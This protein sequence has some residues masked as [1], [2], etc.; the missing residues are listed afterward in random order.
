MFGIGFCMNG[1]G[2]VPPLCKEG[3]RI[4]QFTINPNGSSCELKCECNNQ[5]YTGF[6]DKN[7]RCDSIPRGNCDKKG[8]LGGCIM[9]PKPKEYTCATGI[10]TCQPSYLNSRK[11]GDC[12]RL[13]K[14]E[15]E[16]DR[17]RCGDGIDNDCD[18]TVDK[19]DNDCEQY[20]NL[21]QTKSC[22][23]PENKDTINKGSCSAGLV[24]CDSSTGMWP[25]GETRHC[26]YE[27]M[28]KDEVCNGKD[29]DCDG[30][31]DEGLKDCV[32]LK[33]G[34]KE[35]CY[36]GSGGTENRGICRPGTRICEIKGD[37]TKK[38][39]KCTKEVLPND[40]DVC[41]N[42]LDDNCNGVIDEG[43]VCTS[44]ST[45]P[46]GDDLGQCR[47]GIQRCEGGRWSYTCY[48]AIGPR[49]E[50]CDGLDNNCNGRVDE[51]LVQK[52]KTA[53]GQGLATCLKGAWVCDGPSPSLETCN[54]KDDDCDGKIDN[55]LTERCETNCGGGLRVCFLGKWG[56][57]EPNE[58]HAETCNDKDDNCNGKTDE[59]LVKTCSSTC[60]KGVSICSKGTWAQC[61]A[62]LPKKEICDGVD[63]DCNGKIDDHSSC[64]CNIGDTQLCYSGTAGG[65]PKVNGTFQCSSPC[66]TGQ[67]VC[68]G[69]K[70]GPC[71]GERLP[72]QE[73]CN[74]VDDD[75]SGKVDDG[76]SK[77][78]FSG[79]LGC[80]LQSNGSYK[81]EGVC[82]TGKTTCNKGSWSR[83]I[84]EKL[85]EIERCDGID[86]DCD[87]QTDEG[88]KRSCFSGHAGCYLQADGSH[89]CVSPCKAGQMTCSQG[90]W[91][92]CV[93]EMGPKVEVC[94][95]KD[96]DCNGK[97]D[98]GLIQVCTTACGKG[99]EFCTKGQWIG[100]TAP[101]AK[102]EVCNNQDDDC[103][104]KVDE[105]L[106]QPCYTGTKGCTRQS[107]GNY[108][109]VG[110]C[111]AGIKSCQS[112]KWTSCVGEVNSQKE[113][114][115]YKD[116]D[117]DGV[118][119]NMGG[120]CTASCGLV[121]KPFCRYN[122]YHC[123]VANP[124]AEICDGKDNDCDGQVDET[125]LKHRKACVPPNAIGE[126]KN[127]GMYTACNNGS[128][129]CSPGS[130]KTETCNSKDDDCDG[131][132]DEGILGCVFTLAGTGKR[133]D[134]DGPALLAEFSFP[135]GA[136][137]VKKGSDEFV[138]VVD[139][140]N[141]KIKKINLK[142]HQVSTWLGSKLGFK[143]G[144]GTQSQ[145]WSP[146]G[147]VG[148]DSN[149]RYYI[150]E[151][152]NQGIR[153]VSSLG[154]VDTFSGNPQKAGFQDGLANSALFFAPSGLALSGST[155]FLADTGNERI[156]AIN[157]SDGAVTTLA[158]H[159]TGNANGQTSTATFDTPTS[160]A[161][162][163]NNILVV[164]DSGNHL[165]RKIDLNTK[166]V[167]TLA[168]KSKGYFDGQ[169]SQALFNGPF[170]IAV[171]PKGDIYISDT[172]NHCIRKIDLLRDNVITA[173][174]E[175]GLPG[176]RDAIR[177]SNASFNPLFR[178]PKYIS[179]DASGYLY[180][181]D[182]GN[183]CI[184][185][186]LL[187]P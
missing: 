174:G 15:K 52:C 64:I 7:G 71:S 3:D 51:H 48:G 112:G 151:M 17:K 103:D 6:C 74:N 99:L 73:T 96:N 90:K 78:C 177:S 23:S 69:G 186:V 4:S 121:G 47:H 27:I 87:G 125:F 175:C 176:Y 178:S 163:P 142:T 170:G 32:C 57:C 119:D 126:C 116:N 61:T 132:I 25:P 164:V 33:E 109:C 53:C 185:K 56:K 55:N 143:N 138:L 8:I 139:S 16:N 50:V 122:K 107:G 141:H 76:L 105:D 91:G 172:N 89:R 10:H 22:Y 106:S 114:C 100:C 129:V 160:I 123:V 110:P 42:G 41:D 134:K 5:H 72:T 70:W 34:D 24:Y 145:F 187:E 38:W 80:Q 75:C 81:C 181:A 14:T 11:W 65:C 179:F 137:Y 36:T 26:F 59:G 148:P 117:C 115:D 68:V 20:C 31:V 154:V 171:S 101:S 85:P 127:S 149:G 108:T 77:T 166:T 157:I 102:T 158:G 118:V 146:T 140:A 9:R 84:G 183:H 44:G 63:N 13:D 79:P 92:G 180:I 21:G 167:S 153:R 19:A 184:R 161:V 131:L 66:Q 150:T 144:T 156:R 49:A 93:G 46:C 60:G 82:Q 88:L 97:I 147:I 12:E 152:I 83:C 168:G 86:N 159:S 133:G 120:T 165:I 136:H 30:E 40:K 111:K 35:P 155:L 128:L 54:N 39:S 18:G 58:I 37:K 45:R 173:I 67:Q 124:P 162:L 104:G 62:P 98:E 2:G 1:C 29:D 28:P 182:S 43:C 169:L 130:K 94:D 135:S 95:G 113:V